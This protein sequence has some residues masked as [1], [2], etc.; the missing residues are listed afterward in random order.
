MCFYLLLSQNVIVIA[1]TKGWFKIKLEKSTGC[2]DI[3]VPI[4]RSDFYSADIASKGR[5][6][7]DVD[8]VL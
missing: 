4:N 8:L 2:W 1:C 5:L 7:G 6:S 3:N